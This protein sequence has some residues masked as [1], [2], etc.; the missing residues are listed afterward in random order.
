MG[1]WTTSEV[2]KYL[3]LNEKKIYAMVRDGKLP[4]ARICG[5]WLFEKELIDQWVRQHTIHPDAGVMGALVDRMLVLQGSDDWLLDQAIGKV[6]S[7]IDQAIVSARVG[8]FAGLTALRE[9]RAHFAG[10]HVADDDL[11]EALRPQPPTYLIGLFGRHQVLVVSKAHAAGVRS[12]SDV[13][14]QGLRFAIRQ[15]AAGTYRLTESLVRGAGHSM[16]QLKTV[17]PFTSHL[18]VAL[19]VSQGHADA[20]IV[21]QVAAELTHQPYVPLLDET[22][23]LAVPAPLFG[24][25]TVA[26]FLDRLIGWLDTRTSAQAPGYSFEPLGRLVAPTAST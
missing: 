26:S 20:G 11:Q 4:A 1:Y 16:Q 22:Y 25:P 2:A 10:I 21:I 15:K 13:V 7:I 19:A 8:S 17:G 5:K 24:H 3:R 12:L 18:E 9:G 6:R 23:R 14:E